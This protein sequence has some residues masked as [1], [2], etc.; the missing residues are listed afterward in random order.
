MAKSV[1]LLIL[2]LVMIGHTE[3]Q[4]ATQGLYS[5]PTTIVSSRGDATTGYCATHC[6]DGNCPADNSNDRFYLTSCICECWKQGFDWYS[7]NFDTTDGLCT[8]TSKLLTN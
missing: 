6:I 1:V 3:A 2:A 8:C 4:V 7:Y 5:G